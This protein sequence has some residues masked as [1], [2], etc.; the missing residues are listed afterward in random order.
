[1]KDFIL[2]PDTFTSKGNA[3]SPPEEIC[4]EDIHVA[5]NSYENKGYGITELSKKNLIKGNYLFGLHYKNKNF[6]F[7]TV[8]NLKLF[9]KNPVLYEMVKLPDKLPV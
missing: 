5:Q 7:S 1:M 4:I 9:Q 3:F 6:L 2:N 8:K